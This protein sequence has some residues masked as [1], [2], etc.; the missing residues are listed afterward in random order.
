MKRR[1][2]YPIVCALLVL[3][4]A[5]LARAGRPESPTHP[6]PAHA[7]QFEDHFADTS[8]LE[9]VANLVAGSSS[10][11]LVEQA[12][13]QD[14]FADFYPGLG[15][16]VDLHAQPGSVLLSRFSA[17][18]RVNDVAS[19]L[20]S[21]V[22]AASSQGAGVAYLYAVWVDGRGSDLEIYF[23]RS[24]DGGAT[25]GTSR[26]LSTGS[27]LGDQSHPAIAASGSNVYAVWEDS[28]GVH[29]SRS[30]NYG[31]DWP[32]SN[33]FLGLA[34]QPDIAAGYAAPNQLVYLVYSARPLSQGIDVFSR[35]SNGGLTWGLVENLN[36]FDPEDTYQYAP[37]V[38][39]AGSADLVWAAYEQVSGNTWD[40]YAG[41]RQ[42]DGTWASLQVDSGPNTSQQREPAIFF[43][44]GQQTPYCLWT[45]DRNGETDLYWAR[46]QDSP[47]A[48]Q[49]MGALTGPGAGAH[50]P[51]AVPVGSA[52]WAA[53]T[54]RGPASF[55]TIW[56]RRHDGNAWGD[57]GVVPDQRPAATHSGAAAAQGDLDGQVVA[58]LWS[59]NRSDAGDIF[60][61][62]STGDYQPSGVYTSTVHDFAGLAA[63]G[64]VSWTGTSL[65]STA[66]AVRSGNTPQ[67]GPSWSPWTPVDNGAAVPVPLA[68]YLQYRVT[69]ARVAPQTSPALTLLQVTGYPARSGRA[70]SIPVGQCVASWGQFSF[71]GTE[72]PGTTLTLSILDS[73]GAVLY[74]D[75]GTPFDLSSLSPSL[76]P[77][78]RL[79]ADVALPK[80]DSPL[81]DWWRVTWQEGEYHAAFDFDPVHVY[82]PTLV[83]FFDH[84]SGTVAPSAYAWQFGDGQGSAQPDP[85]HAY[86]HS[87]TYQVALSAS[88]ECPSDVATATLTVLPLPA[89]PAQAAFSHGPLCPGEDI[90]FANESLRAIWWHWSFGD[91]AAS[92]REFPPAHTYAASGDYPFRLTVSNTLGSDA[93][94]EL[95]RVRPAPTAAFTWSAGLLTAT[96]T[97]TV[98]GDPELLWDLGDGFTSTL[99][100]PTHTYAASG[101]YPVTLV[102]SNECA[103]GVATATV[104]VTCVGPA[105]PAL[106][107]APQPLLARQAGT[108]T[109]TVAAGSE[110]VQFTWRFGDA[111]AP[112]SGRVVRHTYAA[113]GD[114]HLTLAASN[115]CGQAEK[116]FPLVV[117]T[118]LHLAYLPV[119]FRGMYFG[120]PFE[121]DNTP[122]QARRLP[123]SA[124]QR[125]DFA[126]RGDVDWVYLELS[127]GVTYYV[128]TRDL[129]GDADTWIYLFL[130]GQYN[131]PL[132]VSDDCNPFTKASCITF[133]P[134]I[135]GRYELR[136]HNG[137]E[138]WGR[139]AG[140]I[141]EA[142]VQ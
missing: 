109:A 45:D 41:R 73:N 24:G 51:A 124:P 65:A 70:V 77:R 105:A 49:E 102:A 61:S 66:V 43:P 121:P 47:P 78:L 39:M 37:S 58:V 35:R 100:H 129:S 27:S 90:T 53:W 87:G 91:G 40:A 54:A 127:A 101:Q 140:Y 95:L 122:A 59:D 92:T 34:W 4:M 83:Q 55:D 12:W 21:Q 75:V 99:S 80:G 93:A 104:K 1:A 28:I 139:G 26:K 97:S 135:S 18:V 108:F 5:P 31:Q 63:W 8:H 42:P 94:E 125:H 138:Q 3:S 23:A 115:A 6:A 20:Q 33:T 79:A 46:Y 106:E 142:M 118:G 110:P 130:P 141:V 14:T 76:Y 137:S 89:A 15:S 13:L 50:D 117:E 120:D 60:V 71:A 119:I 22:D 56:A 114:Y 98:T 67:P 17:N 133:R 44:V 72:P 107:H 84:S 88:G 136:V 74:G 131:I 69:L 7:A 86:A 103:E 132:A 113:S 11:Q 68:R 16:G 10:L 38:A 62:T 29:Y 25:W 30:S 112:Q 116:G 48:W 2:L 36:P 128:E 85:T 123:L 111:S 81:L 126:P 96:F 9:Q 64:T 82:T 57:P 32:T 52:V 134:A 19:G